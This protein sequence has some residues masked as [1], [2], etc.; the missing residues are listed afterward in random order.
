MTALAA[1]G[2]LCLKMASQTGHE[3]TGRSW[4][5]M[6]LWCSTVVLQ[7]DLEVLSCSTRKMHLSHFCMHIVCCCWY[8]Q[9]EL[10]C[11]IVLWHALK[12]SSAQ[13][14]EL[15]TVKCIMCSIDRQVSG[16]RQDSIHCV[17]IMKAFNGNVTELAHDNPKPCH[18]QT[19]LQP[20]I[21]LL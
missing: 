16:C 1:S 21:S 11:A 7:S 13:Y 20:R 18:L 12:R 6:Q 4:S 9:H 10:S 19:A 5:R 3:V 15:Y 2:L 17:F 14:P 8:I